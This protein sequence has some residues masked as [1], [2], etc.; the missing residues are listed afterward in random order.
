MMILL[1]LSFA[2]ST[3]FEMDAT[4]ADSLPSLSSAPVFDTY[5]E[6]MS[7]FNRLEL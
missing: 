2:R 7:S 3:A 6:S 1:D 5:M 4:G